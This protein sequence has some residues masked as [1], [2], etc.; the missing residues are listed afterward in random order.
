MVDLSAKNFSEKLEEVEFSRIFNDPALDWF[1]E[2]L[3]AS[4]KILVLE[5]PSLNPWLVQA[6]EGEKQFLLVDGYRRMR[7]LKAAGFDD[8]SE[9]GMQDHPCRISKKGHSSVSVA[10][11]PILQTGERFRVTVPSGSSS[12]SRKRG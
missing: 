6:Q 10:K 3:E 2:E 9:A 11:P 4:E 12:I 5:N 8:K 7:C 1:P